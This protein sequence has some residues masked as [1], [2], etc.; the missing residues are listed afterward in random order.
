MPIPLIHYTPYALAPLTQGIFSKLDAAGLTLS[1]IFG[2]A[3]RDTDYNA[4]HGTT[5]TIKDYDIRIWLP[6]TEFSR[7]QISAID[8]LDQ[9]FGPHHAIPADGTAHMRYIFNFMGAEL[10]VSLRPVPPALLN[11]TIPIEAVALNRAG[12]SDIGLCAVAIDP[13]L[14]GWCRPEYLKDLQNKSLTV[15]STDNAQRSATYTKRMQLKF[16][17]HRLIAL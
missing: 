9:Q 8:R 10:D 15:F 16:P 2:G 4:R 3:Q 12:D 6:D 14:R 13:Q 7:A 11:T 1:C 17:D 5:R